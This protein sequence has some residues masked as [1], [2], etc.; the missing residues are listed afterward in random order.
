MAMY[1]FKCEKCKGDFELEFKM[2]DSD[3]R[4]NAKC[5]DCKSKLIR[6]FISPAA[7]V[8]ST[9]GSTF[10]MSDAKTFIDHDG[11]PIRMKFMDHGERGEVAKGSVAKKI[12]GA[13]WDHKTGQYVVDVMSNVPDPLGRLERSKQAGNV[14]MKKIKVG[15]KFKTRK[16]KK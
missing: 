2:S 9:I 10:S 15:Q 16:V 1:L 3:G 4:S 14:D 12:K 7:I 8:K 13:R 5:P 11:R 6:V